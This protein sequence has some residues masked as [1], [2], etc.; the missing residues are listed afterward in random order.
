MSATMWHSR[1][2]NRTEGEVNTKNQHF[3]FTTINWCSWQF[4]YKI[5]SKNF[6]AHYTRSQ[7][8]MRYQKML[9]VSGD[10]T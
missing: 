1:E 6:R 3:R 7:E 10:T 4:V 5:L 8:I 9:K 2:D